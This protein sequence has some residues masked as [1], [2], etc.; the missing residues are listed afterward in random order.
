MTKDALEIQAQ[1]VFS[2]GGVSIQTPGTFDPIHGQMADA[3][4]LRHAD[5][6]NVF[7]QLPATSNGHALVFLAGYGQSRAG[8]QTTPDGRPGFSDIFLK[9]G[10]GVYLVDQPRRGEAGQSSVPVT[11]TAKPDDLNWFTQFRLGLW[12]KFMEN[13]Q[14]PQDPESIDQF[15]RQMTPDT[16]KLDFGVITAAMIAVFEKSGPA[17]LVSHSQGGMPGWLTAMQSDNVQGVIAI[18]PG[19]FV[20]PKAE[21]PAKIE[22]KYPMPVQGVAVSDAEFAKLISKPITVYYGDNIPTAP[23]A[24]PAWDF[25][26]GAKQLAYQFADVVNA[27]GGDAKIVYLPDEGI[28]GNDHFMFEDLNNQTVADHMAAWLTAKGLV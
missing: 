27:H 16:G 9:K 7:Y 3:G 10:Y 28:H 2:A 19:S 22:T 21:L 18:E 23:S 8:W 11:L 6:A 25:W 5:H 20:F 26:R 4:Q 1:G 17:I 12:P 15:F 13:S 24:V 14:F